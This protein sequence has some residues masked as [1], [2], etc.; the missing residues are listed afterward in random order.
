M[1]RTDGAGPET[2]HGANGCYAELHRSRHIP[3]TIEAHGGVVG[4]AMRLAPNRSKHYE[5]SSIRA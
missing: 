1:E 3:A 2:M 5:R 4:Q